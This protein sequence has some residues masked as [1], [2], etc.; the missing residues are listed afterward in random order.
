MSLAFAAAPAPPVAETGVL[1]GREMLLATAAVDDDDPA[2]AATTT[3]TLAFV[4]R[5]PG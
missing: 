2:A 1:T 5:R 3:G 4:V